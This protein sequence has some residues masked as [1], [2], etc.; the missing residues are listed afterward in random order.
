MQRYH[1]ALVDSNDELHVEAAG[2]TVG[3]PID[4]PVA[5]H[6]DV[7]PDLLHWTNWDG[8]DA[9]FGLRATLAA[10]LRRDRAPRPG[11]QPASPPL[12]FN[13]QPRHM[14]LAHILDKVGRD[15]EG[16]GL[17]PDQLRRQC[18]RAAHLAALNQLPLRTDPDTGRLAG[19]TTG[20]GGDPPDGRGGRSGC[21]CSCY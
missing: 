5:V 15:A 12:P 19:V 13:Q 1:A 11:G 3:W 18:Q 16:R 7:V 14:K 21:R 2:V 4:L 9:W 17:G 6:L 10:S 20:G 8:D